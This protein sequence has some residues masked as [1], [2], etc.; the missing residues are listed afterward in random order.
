MLLTL[1]LEDYV[2]GSFEDQISSLG[3]DDGYCR[4]FLY[5]STTPRVFPIPTSC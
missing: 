1:Y 3:P 4:M 5:V 2:G